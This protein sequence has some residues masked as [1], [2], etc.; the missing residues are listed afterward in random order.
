[1]ICSDYESRLIDRIAAKELLARL[2]P[3]ERRAVCRY[4]L[5]DETLKEVGAHIGGVTP[6]RVRQIV[7]KAERKLRHAA[8]PPEPEAV[9]R[10]AFIS[11]MRDLAW[12]R[13]EVEA[14]LFAHERAEIDRMVDNEQP[15]NEAAWESAHDSYKALKAAAPPKPLWP[16]KEPLFAVWKPPPKV[17]PQ[18]QQWPGNVEP[19][20][21]RSRVPTASDMWQIANYAVLYFVSV[22]RWHGK[23]RTGLHTLGQ[24]LLTIESPRDAD[25]IATNVS[26]LVRNLQSN[27]HL[28][29][30]PLPANGDA[31]TVAGGVA[32]RVSL[33]E[34]G[35][36]VLIEM[37]YDEL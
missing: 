35:Q 24:L 18:F 26:I 11:H 30:C 15:T 20:F 33:I 13:K 14:R 8:K 37:T 16:P 1:M 12:S 9:A 19:W 36:S 29:A 2:Q 4:Y 10:E 25:A 28:S 31:T 27:V 3:R 17:P 6:E 22:H 21:D 5:H 34:A 7:L 23:C 32:M